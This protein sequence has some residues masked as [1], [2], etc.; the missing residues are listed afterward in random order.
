MIGEIKITM[1]Q[2][3][4]C[5]RAA[6]L[7]CD[8][9]ERKLRLLLPSRIKGID[10]FE[11]IIIRKNAISAI[12][13]NEC[14]GIVALHHGKEGFINP[15]INVFIQTVGLIRGLRGYMVF[16]MMRK[17]IPD[18]ELRIESFAVM[19]SYRGKGIGSLLLAE[20]DRIAKRNGYKTIS[21]EVV[22]TNPDARRLYERKGFIE[23]KTTKYPIL[24]NIAGFSA[25]TVMKKVIV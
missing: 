14:V 6:E 4:D 16:R 5:R 15:K 7:F 13:K 21:L 8:A 9:F 18:D 23:E 24:R 17:T 19:S 1:L 11:K 25:V 22:N 2:E 20:V 3:N 12:Y 10:L